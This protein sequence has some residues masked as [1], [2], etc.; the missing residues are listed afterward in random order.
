MIGTKFDNIGPIKKKIF[1]VYYLLHNRGFLLL[2]GSVYWIHKERYAVDYSQYLGPEWKADYN[3]PATII[4]NHSCWMVRLS[5]NNHG[6]GYFNFELVLPS[7]F[8]R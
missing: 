6:L 3:K 4:G 1:D 8:H 5:N 2:V 7:S